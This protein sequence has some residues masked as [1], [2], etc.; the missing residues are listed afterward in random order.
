MLLYISNKSLSFT[1]YLVH[2]VC[3]PPMHS[4]S[5]KGVIPL[6]GNQHCSYPDSWLE[7]GDRLPQQRCWCILAMASFSNDNDAYSDCFSSG[8]GNVNRDS[9]RER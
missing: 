4:L 3:E 2:S 7:I 5:C 1:R 9:L 6:G 8:D